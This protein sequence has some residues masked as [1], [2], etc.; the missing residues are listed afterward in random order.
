MTNNKPQPDDDGG[1]AFPVADLSKPQYPGMSLR[2]H[3][4]GRCIG[5]IITTA[6][7]QHTPAGYDFAAAQAYAQADAMIVWK[8]RWEGGER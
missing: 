3:F 2:D 5:A 4:A 1:P 8:R 6:T 7:M